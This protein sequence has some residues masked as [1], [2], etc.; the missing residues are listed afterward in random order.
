MGEDLGL[1]KEQ[2]E[3]NLIFTDAKIGET[4]RHRAWTRPTAT[5]LAWQGAAGPERGRAHQGRGRRLDLQLPEVLLRGRVAPDGLEQH[6]VPGRIDAA[7]AVGNAGRAA[8]GARAQAQGRQRR[9][10]ACHKGE[11]QGQCIKGFAFPMRRKAAWTPSNTI[12]W[13]AT[14]AP[15]STTSA[16]PP[17]SSAKRWASGS[18][19]S[20]PSY[21][22]GLLAED[23]VLARRAL[24]H[25]FRRVA[26]EALAE[27]LRV[28][29]G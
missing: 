24:S 11:S 20:W 9:S 4:M 16:S 15:S 28:S 8:R 5:Q 2:V 26:P 21:V 27:S 7:R 13:P 1:T 18:S 19:C 10:E 29:A 22:L 17:P 3:Q 25:A 12:A 23:R 14:S 6:R